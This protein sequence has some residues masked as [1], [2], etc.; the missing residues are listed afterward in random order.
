MQEW[1]SKISLKTKLTHNIPIFKIDY[2]NLN[3]NLD[4]LAILSS[5]I[6]EDIKAL[7]FPKFLTKAVPHRC[8]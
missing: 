5:F 3:I 2:Q 4:F 8:S 7:Q 6:S 1:N